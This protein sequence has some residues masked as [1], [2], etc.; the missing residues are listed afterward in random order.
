MRYLFPG[1]L[2][3]AVAALFFFIPVAGFEIYPEWWSPIGSIQ[4]LQKSPGRKPGGPLFFVKTGD[5]DYFRIRGNGEVAVSGTVTDG[6]SA[7]SGDGRFYV[8][9][10]KSGTSLELFN[11]KGDRFWKIESLEYPYLSRNGKL[12]LLMNGDQSGFRAV[13]ENGNPLPAAIS[14]RI[15]TAVVF[16][17]AG[18]CA[19]VGF[20]DGSY[21]F[22]SSK[23]AVTGRGK[24]PAGTMVKSMAVSGNGRFAAVHYGNNRKDFI[25][26]IDIGDDDY[27]DEELRH[28]HQ[29]KTSVFA[30]DDG[31]F[32]IID[33][34]RVLY[35]TSSG[36][37]RYA[38]AIPPKRE[39]HSAISCRDGLYA[40]SYTMK[41][42]TSKL[43]LYRDNGVILFSR[44][45]PS[46]SFLDSS[47]GNDLLFLRGS[48]NIY[49]YSIQGLR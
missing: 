21:Y 40:V 37:I 15:A 4:N 41:N 26:V 22:V 27:D 32:T 23:G 24:T 49:C 38:I 47:L 44:E 30:G 29:V 13:D 48:D 18:D 43:I 1:L 12:I 39:G 6:L 5:R 10:Q 9:Y 11:E 42:G 17:P 31:F 33:V 2:A 16:S 8:K 20:F 28:V 25:R 19:G 14:G 46:E 36:R 45:F 3:G 34:D 35:L 7:F